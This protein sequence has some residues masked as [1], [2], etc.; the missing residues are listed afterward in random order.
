MKKQVLALMLAVLALSGIFPA[1]AAE[2]DCF[3]F[4][5]DTVN[6]TPGETVDVAIWL[7]NNPGVTSVKLTVEYDSALTLVRVTPNGELGGNFLVSPDGRYPVILNWYD[8]LQNVTDDCMLAVLTFAVPENGGQSAFPVTIT[9]DPD[10]IFDV[11]EEQVAFAIENGG[12]EKSAP[13]R[14]NAFFVAVALGL[15]AALLVRKKKR[16]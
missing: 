2:R 8:G 15:V 10:D 5:V 4:S 6:A 14:K 16:S 11:N 12:V 9:C 7:K 13:A 1:F 3:V